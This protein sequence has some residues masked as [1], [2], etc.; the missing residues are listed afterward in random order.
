MHLRRSGPVVLGF[1]SARCTPA[2][3]LLVLVVLSFSCPWLASAGDNS[4]DAAAL[5]QFAIQTN[6]S[7]WLPP[8]NGGVPC[9]KPWPGV[10]CNSQQRVIKVQLTNYGSTGQFPGYLDQLDALEVLQLSNGGIFGSLPDSWGAAFSALQQLDLSSNIIS[11][12]VPDAW[13]QSQAF[14]ALSTLNLYGAFNKNTTRDLP[15]QG[16]QSGM[17]NLTSLNLG[18]CNIT[19]TLPTPWGSGFGRLGKLVLSNNSLTGG[20]PDSWG[21]LPGT[22]SLTELQLNSN[23]FGGP[24]NAAWGSNGSFAQLQ[25]LNLG[26]NALTDV[27]PDAW[28]GPGSLPD[29]QILQLD[30]NRLSGSLPAS[31]ANAGALANLTGIYLQGNNLTGGIT[32]SWANNRS[33]VIKYLRPG[34][35][36]MCEPIRARLGGVRAFGSSAPVTCLEGG[37]NQDSDISSALSLGP[38]ATCTVTV[39]SDGSIQSSDCPVGETFQHLGF[40]KPCS[41]PVHTECTHWH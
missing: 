34:N 18:L 21:I 10:T 23:G 8:L 7:T 22:A 25:W 11:G 30:N 33:R 26:S 13:T 36:H 6:L 24:L 3:A 32:L 15:F 12:G 40:K 4:T 9:S 41:C 5:Q 1:A 19:G 29:L 31:W 14:P 39:A 27:L 35:Q 20:L 28:A 38:D 16:A 2:K 37:C 17:A